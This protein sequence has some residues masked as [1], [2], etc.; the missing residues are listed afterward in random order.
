MYKRLIEFYDTWDKSSHHFDKRFP[1]VFKM[2]VEAT[3]WLDTTNVK[4]RWWHVIHDTH[5]LPKCNI[6]NTL[7][8]WRTDNT[9]SSY[10]SVKCRGRSELT[11]SKRKRTTAQR[12][13]A[14]HF[15]HTQTFSDK[16]KATCE[17]RYGVANAAQ[18]E[19]VKSKREATCL[20]KYGASSFSQTDAYKAKN[21]QT[22]ET[23]YGCS[24]TGSS[25][26]LHEVRRKSLK[27]KYGV[28]NANQ[29]HLSEQQLMLIGNKEWL[30]EQ[31]VLHKRSVAEIAEEIGV[32][33]AGL[34]NR[35]KSLSID[36]NRYYQSKG[37]RELYEFILSL[38]LSA[39]QNDRSILNGQ[40]LDIV[41][42]DKKIAIEYNGVFWHSEGNGKTRSYHKQKYVLAKQQGYR[43]VQIWE[44]EW[45]TSRSKI[46]ARLKHILCSSNTKI[47]ARKCVVERLSAD[48]YRPFLELHHTQGNCSGVTLAYGLI[49][50]QRLVAVMTF[51]K[52]RFEQNKWELLRY[53]SSCAVVGGA[54]KLFKAMINDAT[55]REVVS[56]SDL[57]WGDGNVYQT[58]GMVFVHETPPNYHYFHASKPLTLMSRVRFQK[59]KLGAILADYN[60]DMSEWDNMK[61]N[62]YDRIW[63]CGHAKYTYLR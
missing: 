3:R 50:N 37:E 2:L 23:K 47:F 36:I 24:N 53:A 42:E 52:S 18:H 17:Q 7:V 13:G 30:E 41:I 26:E 1:E 63:D 48:Q 57:R 44:N 25:H 28:D 5:D 51:G 46:E 58:I 35:M 10:C 39:K 55:P 43:L 22:C 11:K 60:P 59:H 20:E 29:I 45:I 15:S 34:W 31:H 16:Y 8:E 40:E 62:N 32:S 38:G 27:S 6:C 9:Y 49:Y 4:Q 19:D 12:Y 61:R 54:S 33:H 21:K 56:Y 14:D